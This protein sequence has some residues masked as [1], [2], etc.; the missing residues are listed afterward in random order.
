[1]GAI[2]AV[3]FVLVLL[4]GWKALRQVAKAVLIGVL[5]RV[6]AGAVRRA[7]WPL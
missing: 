3:L 6:L 1:M 7:M 4:A 5:V 2:V